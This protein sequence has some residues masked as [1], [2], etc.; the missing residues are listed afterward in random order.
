MIT[1]TAE[2]GIENKMTCLESRKGGVSSL[3]P[4][5]SPLSR[6]RE[7]ERGRGLGWRVGGGVDR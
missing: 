2:T 6:G 7:R 4:W 3:P 5:L 1:V